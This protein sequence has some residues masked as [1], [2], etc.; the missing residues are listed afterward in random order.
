MVHPNSTLRAADHLVDQLVAQGITAA[1][2]VPG[3]SY[4]PVLDAFY[5][6]EQDI[7]FIT[8]RQEGGAA[9]AADAYGKL[10]GRP[11]ICFATR[12]PGATN[13]SAGVHVAY[14]DSTPMILFLGQVAR[15]M[16][17]REAFQE[18]DYRRMFGQMTKWV[19]Q[20]DDASRLQEYVSRAFR[21]AM[22]GRPGPVVLALPEDM[23]YD[24]IV[25]P[26]PPARVETPRFRPASD[27]MNALKQRITKAKSPLIMAGGGGWTK[28]G[29]D[30]LARFAETQGLPLSVSLRCQSLIDNRHPNYIGHY[31]VGTPPYLKTIMAETDLL[32]AIGPRLGEMTTAGYTIL[33]APVPEQSLVHVFPEPEEIGRVY[34]PDLALV[35]DT[36]SFCT[37]AASWEAI[38]R[39]RFETRTSDLHQLYVSFNDPASVAGDPLAPY[40]AH[41]AD[42][43][44]E[45]AILCNGAGN[46]AGWLHRFYR[47]RAPGSQLAPTSGSMGYGLP[48]AIGAAIC[49]PDREVFAIAGDGCFMMTCQEMATAVHHNLS[50]TVII[51]DNARYGTIRAHQEREYPDRVSGTGLTNPDFCAF[52]RSFGANADAVDDYDSFVTAVAAA[53]AR[54]GV[55]L[56]AVTADPSY[57]SPGNRLGQGRI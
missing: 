43:L 35:A 2:G 29:I 57:L 1:F 44:P 28:T 12:G 6:R 33:T 23:L 46:Y 25:Q 32:I 56:I 11:G 48:A 30:A 4:L 34:Q 8:C 22:S 31:G 7:R 38:A 16:V 20:I 40:F 13:A 50:L 53:R 51:I 39:D 49:E 41:L 3:E 26:T 42:T 18:I 19:A 52:A 5:G 9:M 15:D 54:G 14:Q 37:E 47:Y 27:A 17:D 45:D 55:N 36:Q 10:T 24:E 21:T